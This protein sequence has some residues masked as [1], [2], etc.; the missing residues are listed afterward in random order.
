MGSLSLQ[1]GAGSGVPIAP[2]RERRLGTGDIAFDTALPAVV[3]TPVLSGSFE[4][5]H[6][7]FVDPI[8]GRYITSPELCA[9]PWIS[10]ISSGD[11]ANGESKI[12]R[13][14]NEGPK[15]RFV[16]KI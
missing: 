7:D 5:R 12:N 13:L 15:R 2:V 14:G 6:G 9:E 11:N 4:Q 1:A 16:R 8:V 10:G 3:F